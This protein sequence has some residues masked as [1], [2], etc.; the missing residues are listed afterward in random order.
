MNTRVFSPNLTSELLVKS[1]IQET[2]TLDFDK[3]KYRLLDLGSG[4]CHVG[5]QV[6]KNLGL[7]QISPSDLDI[8]ILSKSVLCLPS[9]PHLDEAEQL[10]VINIIRGC[11]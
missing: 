11:I 5:V 3:E 1:A 4:G 9:F 7:S 10:G 8:D 2:S 6:A